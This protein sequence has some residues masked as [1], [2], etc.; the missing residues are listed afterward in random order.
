MY[1]ILK[2]MFQFRLPVNKNIIISNK[3]TFWEKLIQMKKAGG[4][5]LQVGATKDSHV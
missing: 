1:G 3:K 4:S 2:R 5:S